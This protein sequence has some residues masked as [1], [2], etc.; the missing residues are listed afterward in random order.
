MRKVL[1]PALII[2]GAS[3][4]IMRV[5]F[6]QI[7]DDSYKLKSENNA[8]KIKFCIYFNLVINIIILIYKNQF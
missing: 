8:I 2:I 1:L 6:L 4:L 7:I 5:F 3:L